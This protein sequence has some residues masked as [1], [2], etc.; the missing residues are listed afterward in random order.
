MRIAIFVSYNKEDTSISDWNFEKNLKEI[1]ELDKR[2]ASRM[3]SFLG[4][5]LLG[6]AYS[7]WSVIFI[8]LK[9]IDEMKLN[10]ISICEMVRGAF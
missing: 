6:H 4:S 7:F 10:Q 2:L 9:S 5:R 8:F 1:D 3:G